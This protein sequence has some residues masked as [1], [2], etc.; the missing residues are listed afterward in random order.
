MKKIIYIILASAALLL[1]N[2]CERVGTIYEIPD[3]SACVSFP[4]EDAIFEM[5]AS[6]GNKITVELWRGNTK[7]AKS[8]AV[9]IEDGTRGVFKPSKTSFDFADGEGVATIDFTYP[10]INDFGGE[11]YEI[12]LTVA[13]PNQVSPSGVDEMKI[14]AWRK[15]TPVYLG[16]GLFYSDFFEES[17][18][19]DIYT[20]EEAPDYFILPN[21][22]V[23]GT[24]WSFTMKNGVPTWPSS[25]YS[26]YVLQ[27]YPVW[28][29][30]GSSE[31]DNGVLYL[32]VASYY[33]PTLNNYDLGYTYEAFVL[34]EGVTLQ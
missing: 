26:G 13:D 22:W 11:V 8:V 19:Q 18:K 15:L 33:L 1:T 34:P 27:G 23:K 14:Q 7:G 9:E 28:I 24:D 6:D 5:L 29:K 2:A 4:S 31:I 17:W 21:C 16:T 32:N 10:D 3:G 25:F 12:L 30:P 20:T